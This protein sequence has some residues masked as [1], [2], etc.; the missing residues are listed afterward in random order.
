MN[1][2]GSGITDTKLVERTRDTHIIKTLS[3]LRP[4]FYLLTLKL[5]MKPKKRASD[6][7]GLSRK[8]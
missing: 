3:I 6:S 4:A 5:R 7:S 8:R 1:G 2:N